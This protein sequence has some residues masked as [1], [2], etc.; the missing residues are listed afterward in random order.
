MKTLIKSLLAIC[1]ISATS[2]IFAS[3]VPCPAADLVVSYS[4]RIDTVQALFSD[5]YAVMTGTEE[6]ENKFY[7]SES[8]RYWGVFAA[9]GVRNGNSPAFNQAYREGKK[10]IHAV[11][12]NM[13]K[14]AEEDGKVY[15]CKYGRGSEE[16]EVAAFS[17]IN[18]SQTNSRLMKSL[19]AHLQLSK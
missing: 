18:D 12:T 9:V 17:V 1:L 13:N 3:Q 19:A 15:F 16:A 4:D 2:Q 14:Y 8:N 5:A 6:F 11:T 7:D 10:L